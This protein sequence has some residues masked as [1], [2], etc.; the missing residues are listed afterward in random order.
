MN[1]PLLLSVVLVA[2]V[3]AQSQQPPDA[4]AGKNLK[5]RT[6]TLRA[7]VIRTVQVPR[8]VQ[9]APLQP[10]KSEFASAIAVSVTEVLWL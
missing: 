1:W 6:V 5:D 8:P 10:A 9:P 7:C 4:N 2:P 3:A